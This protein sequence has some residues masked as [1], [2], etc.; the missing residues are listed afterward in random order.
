MSKPEDIPQWAWDASI[1]ALWTDAMHEGE[2]P[3]WMETQVALVARA[4]FGATA[5]IQAER[6]LLQDILDA[7][8]AINAGLPETYVS[9][10]QSI[11]SGEAASAYIRKHGV[12]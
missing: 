12:N 5:E 11:Y 1:K 4:I 6:D 3:E 9:W 10:S 7:R 2:C 8:P